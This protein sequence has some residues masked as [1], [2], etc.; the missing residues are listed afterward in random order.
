[1]PEFEHIHG[2]IPVSG[3][4]YNEDYSVDYH[5]IRTFVDYAISRG[6]HG[7]A[8]TG[9]SGRFWQLTDEERKQITRVTVAQASGRVPV[10]CGVAGTSIQNAVL[11]TQI[12]Q[13][14]GADAVFAMPPY[15]HGLAPD[16]LYEYYE[17]LAQ[18]A[19]VPVIVQDVAFPGGN[20]IPTHVIA[21]LVKEFE[22][23]QYVK[24]ESPRGNLKASEVIAACG[25]SVRVLVG[26]GG[27]GFFDAL[28][29]GCVGC[30]PGPVNIGGLVRCYNAYQTGDLETARRWYE[31]VLP[32]ITLRMQCGSVTREILRRKGA[33]RTT[34]ARPPRGDAPDEFVMK[35]LDKQFML[36]GDLF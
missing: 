3:T 7:L 20:A 15:V 22:I 24:E 30:M 10:V 34:C 8:T 9:G 12:A 27:F 19:S 14:E 25:E 17:A 29:R 36:R 4:P 21:R 1:M 28:N 31:E 13:D 26:S 11:Y 6:I 33:F 16:E 18:V 2:V 5:S 32:L 35:E 23:I